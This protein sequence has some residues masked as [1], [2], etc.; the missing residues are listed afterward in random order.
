[1]KIMNTNTKETSPPLGGEEKNAT[2]QLTPDSVAVNK[3]GSIT[4]K[5]QWYKHSSLTKPFKQ[6]LCAAIALLPLSNHAAFVE[7][8]AQQ[9]VVDVGA[10]TDFLLNIN[11]GMFPL[12]GWDNNGNN[13][14]NRYTIKTPLPQGLTLY[15]VNQ[16]KT[17]LNGDR[18]WEGQTF[19]LSGGA[20]ATITTV[21]YNVNRTTTQGGNTPINGDVVKPDRAVTVRVNAKPTI[22]VLVN[23]NIPVGQTKNVSLGITDPGDPNP[24]IITAQSSDPATVQVVNVI[25]NS[26]NLKA[27]KPG[28]VTIT[29][30]AFDTRLEAQAAFSVDVPNT[31]PNI[32]AISPQ[33][34]D[35]G[36]T[37]KVTFTVSDAE[38]QPGSLQVSATSDNQSI[39]ANSSFVHNNLGGIRE[40]T[41]KGGA[42]GAATITVKVSDG[43]LTAQTA[44]Q[45]T[46]NN[47]PPL[48]TTNNPV[49]IAINSSKEI[50]FQVSDTETPNDIQV[51]AF[52]QNPA[53]IPDQNLQ[54]GGT[55][56]NMTLNIASGPTTGTLNI[57]IQA[58]DGQF[59]TA[60][61]IQVTVVP[62]NQPPTLEN[63]AAFTVNR[64]A[65]KAIATANLKV[66]DTDNTP[67]ELIYVLQNNPTNG[68]VK[69]NGE[70]TSSF[71]QADIDGGLITYTHDGN[72]NS[73]VDS[74]DFQVGDQINPNLGPFTLAINILPFE[75]DEIAGGD[76][77]ETIDTIL[78]NGLEWVTNGMPGVKELIAEKGL[79]YFKGKYQGLSA[80]SPWV[81]ETAGFFK[82]K[83][84]KKGR[85]KV[86]HKKVSEKLKWKGDFNSNGVWYVE[87]GNDL[88]ALALTTNKQVYGYIT[89][90]AG[91]RPPSAIVANIAYYN[92]KK[93]PWNG[94]NR[95]LVKVGSET[96]SYGD[97][98]VKINKAGT[99]KLNLNLSDDNSK[100]KAKAFIAQNGTWPVFKSLFKK[101]GSLWSFVHIKSEKGATNAITGKAY[102]QEPLGLNN[103]E[104][105]SQ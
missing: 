98:F 59:V 32:S 10:N 3:G 82:M 9:L 57:T 97:G 44:F 48:I 75:E 74:F 4:T 92:A 80:S 64:S 7:P 21:N 27:L 58:S 81:Q 45:V 22:P 90:T 50:A 63:N 104:F 56:P 23:Q 77:N 103:A 67:Q 101:Q 83:Y 46:V 76:P 96:N 18:V 2:P 99:A 29:V 39:V 11:P 5:L 34:V 72:T 85:G 88:F 12:G 87:R 49:S 89:N 95:F 86:I 37:K 68:V 30:K 1:M 43:Q 26:V 14:W 84:S 78:E 8:T 24:T 65:T 19:R 71:S 25:N 79:G 35:S 105:S 100:V 93:A 41:F 28:S 53:I 13:Q 47:S 16:Q 60:S 31:A 15:N 42:S 52:S 70:V 102:L 94:P 73:L 54:I 20:N 91:A 61:D 33:V 51:T 40:L 69:K 66:V 36:A 17:M 55:L 62:P 38:T 6:V